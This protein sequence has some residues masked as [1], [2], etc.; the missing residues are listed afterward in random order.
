[1]LIVTGRISTDPDSVLE[2]LN[3]LKEGVERSRREPGH[4]TAGVRDDDRLAVAH[5]IDER[6]SPVLG[7]GDRRG[8]HVAIL[9]FSRE[10]NRG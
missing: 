1:M 3:D 10:P 8:L 9:A 5:T 7:L 4:G 6:G 2:L